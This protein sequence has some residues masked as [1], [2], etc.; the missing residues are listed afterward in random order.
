M[1]RRLLLAGALFCLFGLA[2]CSGSDPVQV[3]KEVAADSSVPDKNDASA[4]DGSGDILAPP[5]S[6]P[7]KDDAD[8]EDSDQPEDGTGEDD[9]GGDDVSDVTEAPDVPAD[10]TA[11]A[12]VT[13]STYSNASSVG[14]GSALQF[15][16]IVQ[17]LPEGTYATYLAISGPANPDVDDLAVTFKK[18]GNYNV[19]CVVAWSEGEVK[20]PTP[21]KIAVTAGAAFNV[22]TEL[23][24][25]EVMAGEKVSVTCTFTDGYGNLVEKTPKIAVDPQF[26]LDVLGLQILAIKAG[27]YGVACVEPESMAVDDTPAMLTVNPGLPKVITTTLLDDTIVAGESTQVSCAVEDAYGNEVTDFPVAI[28]LSP[29]LDI[30]VFSVSGTKAGTFQVACVP[31]NVAWDLFTLDPKVLTVIPGAASGVTL[32]PVPPKP[33]YKMFEMVQFIVSAVDDY[34]NVVEGVELL[35][36]TYDPFDEGI[37]LVGDMKYKFE[38][39]GIFTFSACLADNPAVCG[40][41]ELVVDGYGPVITIK[42]PERGATIQGKPAVNVMGNVVDPVSGVEY[43]TI[44]GQ[45]VFPDENGDFIFPITAKQGLN[46]I[47]ALAEDP[48]G[49]KTLHVQAFYYSPVWFKVDINDPEGSKM[50]DAMQFFLADQFFDRPV[51]DYS[52]PDNLSTIIEM[53][54]TSIDIGSFLPNPVASAGPYKVYVG[55][56]SYNPPEIHVFPMPGGIQSQV[57]INNINIGVAAKGTC[58]VLFIDFCPDVSGTVEIDQIN[59]LLGLNISA[60]NGNIEYSIVESKAFMYGLNLDIDGI[61]GFLFGWLINWFIDSY[62]PTIQNMINDM[63]LEQVQGIL[64]GIL[65]ALALNMQFEVPNP[66]DPNAPPVELSFVSTIRELEFDQDGVEVRLDA[67]ILGPKNVTK[68]PLGSIGRASCLKWQPEEFIFT[69]WEEYMLMAIHDDLVNEILFSA[70]YAGLLDM[71]V[72][73]EDFM[74]PDAIG[75]LIEGFD[76]AALGIDDMTIR[77]EFFLPPIITSCNVNDQLLEQLQFQVGDIYVELNMKLLNEPVTMGMFVTMAAEANMEIIDGPEGPEVALSIGEIDPMIAQMTYA[78][79]NMAGIQGIMS[80]L[81]QGLV[82]PS[83]LDSIAESTMASIPLPVINISEMAPE[84]LPPNIV[85]KFVVDKLFRELGYTVLKAHIEAQ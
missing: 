18:V 14:A 76:L 12:E 7:G 11:P 73:L 50:L 68:N 82:L 40:Q 38:T 39:E 56:F 63:M 10:E 85:W 81:I 53:A 4:V 48:N 13:V 64:G 20:D 17:G 44:N 25:S 45:T 34:G 23:S 84:F 33:V 16:C 43:F 27:T 60:N 8:P 37:I 65:D 71:V 26:G 9:S 78:S 72:P 58:K 19:A 67:A 5:D 55:P 22:E 28:F 52:Q 49:F 77:T 15:D 2:A 54:L 59:I 42:F 80:M 57:W 47:V 66:L 24:K 83:L 31:Q 75:G 1:M 36:I 32:S 74:D 41:A 62:T 3:D 21:L 69:K 46:I 30:D 6:G 79:D 35:P 70:W 29:G 61:M 51:H